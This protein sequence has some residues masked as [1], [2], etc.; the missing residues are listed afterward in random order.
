MRIRDKVERFGLSLS[1]NSKDRDEVIKR[2]KILLEELKYTQGVGTV[3]QIPGF[4]GSIEILHDTCGYGLTDIGAMFG[5]SRERIRQ[6]FQKYNLQRNEARRAMYRVWND[7][8]NCFLTV[9]NEDLEG[10]LIEK[11]REERLIKRRENHAKRRGSQ[12][13]AI[14]DFAEKNGRVPTVRELG[15]I[16]G[17][18]G[19]SSQ[20]SI[21]HLW[22]YNFISNKEA[23]DN[24]YRVAGFEERIQSKHPKNTKAA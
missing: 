10:I 21:A 23:I 18:K 19:G 4:I 3:E 14:Q 13:H 5:L 9:S 12:V 20:T 11:S 8:R 2:S 1:W 17:Y 24:L 15:R 7:E 16:L 6:Y 22:G